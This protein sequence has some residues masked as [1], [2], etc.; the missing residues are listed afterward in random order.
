M[1]YMKY[2][3]IPNDTIIFNDKKLHRIVAIR[4]FGDVRIGD[5]GGYIENESNLSHNGDCWVYDNAKVFDNARIQH[6]AIV[7]DE[8][9]ISGKLDYR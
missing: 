2:K 3:F 6:Y 5:I 8:V 4:D 1:M 9:V 7:K